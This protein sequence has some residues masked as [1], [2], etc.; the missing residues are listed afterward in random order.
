M[1]Q[2]SKTLH[3]LA[4]GLWFGMAI[5]FT[6]VVTLSLFDTFEKLGQRPEKERPDWLPL[7][8]AFAKVDTEVNGPKEQGSRAAGSVVGPM[9]TYY[10]LLQGVCG[11]IALGTALA[12]SKHG[13]VQRWRIGLLLA[14]LL[15]ALAGWPVEQK[16][17][18]LRPTRNQKMD[19][20]LQ[21]DASA[22]ASTL[23]EMKAAR[24]EFATIIAVT[25]AMALAGN[26]PQE[27][28]NGQ[29]GG[30]HGAAGLGPAP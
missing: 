6:F 26:V 15:A 24:A 10:Y 25:G 27:L 4:L 13:K 17:S 5:F 12:W 29:Q 21:A 1:N 23:A 11:L 14:A 3:V 18:D 7:P 8:A 19:E 9:F 28:A 2:L 22:S 30:C 16:V 20:Y